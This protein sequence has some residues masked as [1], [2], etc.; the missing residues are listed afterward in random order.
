MRITA[1]AQKDLQ[2]KE[3]IKQN[4][5]ANKDK[6]IAGIKKYYEKKAIDE[7]EQGRQQLVTVIDEQQKNLAVTIN[8][9]QQYMEEYLK[10]M[11]DEKTSLDKSLESIKSNNIDSITQQQFHFDRRATES[12][13]A[14]NKILQEINDNA[15]REISDLRSK[16]SSD[17]QIEISKIQRKMDSGAREF[18]QKLL[19][20]QATQEKD[21]HIKETQFA[22]TK[23]EQM[24]QH[25]DMMQDLKSRNVKE[26]DVRDKIFKTQLE[27]QTIKNTNNLTQAQKSFNER[28]EK[29]KQEHQELI[30]R[31]G[32]KFNKEMQ[33]LKTSYSKEKDLYTDK[34]SDPF[35]HITTIEPLLSEDE[36]N[37]FVKLQVPE[38]EMDGV[39]L[40]AKGRKISLNFTRR[41]EDTIEDQTGKKVSKRSELITR[42]IPTMAILNPRDITQSYQNGELIFK[43]SKL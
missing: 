13:E 39:R 31:M 37:Y 5:I 7:K 10:K 20:Q 41:F 18:D 11:Q 4:L 1:D 15:K 24:K 28:F 33:A 32:E 3:K 14:R 9:K 22:R 29:L 40:S 25:E 8:D 36:K 17:Q 26:L 38:H 2:Q 30:G 23:I 27:Q 35:Y 42:D 19:R 43:I 6:E 21:N 34:T 16:T 12:Q